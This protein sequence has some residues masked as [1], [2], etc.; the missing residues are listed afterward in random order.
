MILAGARLVALTLVTMTIYGLFLAGRPIARLC[1]SKNRWRR[2]MFRGWGRW[3][4]RLMGMRRGAVGD[5]PEPPFILV[6]NHCSYVDIALLASYLD[7]VF[8]A[9]AEIAGWPVVNR[10]C[11]GVGTIFINRG[12][13]M[14]VARVNRLVA[15]AVKEELGVVIFPEGTTTAGDGLLPFKASLLEPAVRLELPVH[16]AALGYETPPG[17]APA[18]EAICWWDDTVFGKH[19]IEMLKLPYFHARVAFGSEPIRATDRKALA[20]SLRDA[21]KGL[22]PLAVRPEEKCSAENH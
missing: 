1:S 14:D 3:A 21:V 20:A 2:V 4:C 18:S 10:L 22:T 6:S 7:C 5:V 16:F 15:E 9:K 12:S 8:I 19:L 13:R 17:A 11:K